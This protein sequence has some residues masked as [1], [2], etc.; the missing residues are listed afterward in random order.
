[1][2]LVWVCDG[3]VTHVVLIH[4]PTLITL[5]SLCLI[6]LKT[7]GGEVGNF[8]AEVAEKEEGLG[9]YFGEFL[10]KVAILNLFISLLPLLP[11]CLN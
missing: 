11:L 7:S 1:M 8:N 9:V 3:F 2:N 5:L 6:L 4:I 10:F